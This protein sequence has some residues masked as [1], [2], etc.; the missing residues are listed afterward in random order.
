MCCDY[1]ECGVCNGDGIADGVCD[2]DGNVLDCARMYG[3]SELK[4]RYKWWRWI[5]CDTDLDNCTS[6][7]CINLTENSLNYTSSENIAG[8]QFTHNTGFGSKHGDALKWF[9][10]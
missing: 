6:Q 8:F 5:E 3:G 4:M 1:D 2:C 9:H 7:V 10:C